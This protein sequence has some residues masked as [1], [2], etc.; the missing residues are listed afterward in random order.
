MPTAAQIREELDSIRSKFD[1]MENRVKAE[2]RDY[3]PAEKRWLD[4]MLG[5]GTSEG[6]IAALNADLDRALRADELSKARATEI[7]TKKLD[8]RMGRASASGS[9]M[10]NSHGHS[11]RVITRGTDVS[12]SYGHPPVA[13]ALGELAKALLGGVNSHTPEPIRNALTTVDNPRGGYLVPERFLTEWL[14][15]ARSKLVLMESGARMLTFDGNSLVI[16]MLESDPTFEA[17]G[18]LTTISDSDPTFAAARLEA[19]TLKSTVLASREVIEDSPVAAEIISASLLRGLVHSVDRI[20]LQGQSGFRFAGLA[21]LEAID[22]TGSV[23]AIDWSD[24]IEAALAIRE[25]NHEPTA[26][27]MHPA[28]HSALFALETGDGTNAARGWLGAPPHLANV[29]MLPTTACPVGTII[30]GDFS[31][32]VWA[33]RQA[34]LLE[35]SADAGDAFQKHGVRIKCTWRGDFIVPRP[36]AFYRLTGITVS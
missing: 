17:T 7:L 15:Y 27:I 8:E 20:G 18:E 19:N 26:A 13:N 1:E 4:D 28:V 22:S 21:N 25:A 2:G 32:F 29:M 5:S 6:K 16:P 11:A 9:V 34:P 36:D 14:D 12:A 3:T 30:M 24:L 35:V 33:V 31:Q 10:R 23:G